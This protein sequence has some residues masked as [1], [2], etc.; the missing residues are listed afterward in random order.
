MEFIE[1]IEKTKRIPDDD[2]DGNIELFDYMKNDEIE[3]LLARKERKVNIN[4]FSNFIHEYEN[5]FL[6]DFLKDYKIYIPWVLVYSNKYES[7]ICSIDFIDEITPESLNDTHN[8]KIK[9]DENTKQKY[10]NLNDI[11]PMQKPDNN[12]IS[13]LYEV[14]FRILYFR[15]CM[16][17]NDEKSDICKPE[18]KNHLTNKK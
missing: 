5:D 9:V 17:L 12:N 6:K 15:E 7:Y 4:N 1:F 14:N 2:D 3:N 8:K 13:K 11:R 10:I 18:W 16:I